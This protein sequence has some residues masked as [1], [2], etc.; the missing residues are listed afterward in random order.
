MDQDTEAKVK[1]ME[2]KGWMTVSLIFEVLGN[3]KEIVEKSLKEHIEK[4]EAI[5]TC[6]IYRKNFSEVEEVEKPIKNL[7]KGYSQYVDVDCMV[8]DL[9]TLFVIAISYGPSSVEIDKPDKMQIK[10]GDL[11]HLV[12]LVAGTIHRIAESGLGG[13]VATPRK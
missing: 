7:D 5:K 12:N 6:F 4:L 11:Q 10:A 3:N 2:S 9:T 1:E 13:I 8:K